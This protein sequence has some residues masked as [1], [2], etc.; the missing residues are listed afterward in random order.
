MIS[1][2][3][4]RA[5]KQAAIAYVLV[6]AFFAVT[7]YSARLETWFD[8]GFV[9]AWLAILAAG[10]VVSLLRLWR[11]LARHEPIT[12]HGERDV[13]RALLSAGRGLTRTSDE[14]V[15]RLVRVVHGHS[16]PKQ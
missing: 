8:D 16:A 5:F 3:T 6:A 10:S 15:H 14:L 13:Y 12:L 4:R 7:S 11:Q 9:I 2:G 1:I